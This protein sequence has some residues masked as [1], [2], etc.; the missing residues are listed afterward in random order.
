MKY[1]RLLIASPGMLLLGVGLLWM[2]AVVFLIGSKQGKENLWNT[3]RAFPN[4][5]QTKDS[6]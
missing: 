3:L 5:M 1:V 4:S 6:Q 2:V